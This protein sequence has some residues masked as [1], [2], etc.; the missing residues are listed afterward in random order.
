MLLSTYLKPQTLH[1]LGL[2]ML[3][4]GGIGLQL[5]KPRVLRD[6]IDMALLGADYNPG[7]CA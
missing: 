2:G 3:L 7:G 5:I 6:L 1:V 4:I